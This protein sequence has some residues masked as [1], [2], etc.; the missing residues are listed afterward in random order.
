MPEY[1]R[2]TLERRQVI[3]NM[4]MGAHTQAD[5]ALAIGA[6]QSTVSRELRRAGTGAY[7]AGRAHA[8]ARKLA[9]VPTVVPLLD[10][11]ADLVRHLTNHLKARYS[12]GQALVLITRK[13]QTLPTI[14]AQAV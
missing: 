8:L 13:H 1:A 2:L 6:N 7:S 10:R 4:S 12:I 5:I 14:S 9:R 3:E 11:R